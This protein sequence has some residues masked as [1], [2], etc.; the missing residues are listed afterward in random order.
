MGGVFTVTMRTPMGAEK[1][2]LTLNEEFGE[3]RGTLEAVGAKHP[4]RGKKLS[5]TKFVISGEIQKFM[6]RIAFTAE[7]EIVG[8][9]LSAIAE[10]RYGKFPITGRRRVF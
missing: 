2:T 4:V 1:G 7:G 8:N 6:L 3:L 10:T 5:D 9:D